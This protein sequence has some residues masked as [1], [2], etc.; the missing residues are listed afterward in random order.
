MSS[1]DIKKKNY[2]LTT[3][4]FCVGYFRYGD[5]IFA[6]FEDEFNCN[7]FFKQLNSLHQSLTFKHEKE[8]NGKLFFLDV[9]VEKSNSKFSTSAYRK[10]SFSCQYN[11][12][13]SFGPKSRKNNLIGTLAHQALAICSPSKLPQQIDFIG[14]IVCSK[15]YPENLINSRIKR[16]IEEFILPLKE[17]PEKM[18]SLP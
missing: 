12:W 7:Q 13:D 6:M 9:L 16:K 18:S 5:D 17:G 1:S 14:L 10:P 15:G 11:R 8:I 3:I 2:L 4:T